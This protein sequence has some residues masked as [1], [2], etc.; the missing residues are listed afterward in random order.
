MV[1]YLEKPIMM[2]TAT[3]FVH[4]LSATLRNTMFCEV[5]PDHAQPDPQ[6]ECNIMINIYLAAKLNTRRD[7][8]CWHHYT[9]TKFVS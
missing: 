8:K 7:N 5:D 9:T 1:S 4:N 2:S 3:T 6:L